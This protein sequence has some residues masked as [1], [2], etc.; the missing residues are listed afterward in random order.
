ML[1]KKAKIKRSI[2]QWNTLFIK[3]KESVIY[4]NFAVIIWFVLNMRHERF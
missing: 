3:K 2:Y 4:F 1:H